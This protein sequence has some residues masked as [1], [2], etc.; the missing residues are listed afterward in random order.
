M[1][2][3]LVMKQ[4]GPMFVYILYYMNNIDH[5]TRQIVGL[6]L[7]LLNKRYNKQFYLMSRQTTKLVVEL[8]FTAFI[9]Q[10]FQGP[11]CFFIRAHHCDIYFF[12]QK[13]AVIHHG[14]INT[15]RKFLGNQSTLAVYDDRQVNREVTKLLD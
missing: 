6:C 7:P 2:F 5:I 14:S 3:G 4:L 9:E 11:P 15:K 12:M 13:Q 10:I 1:L 8:F